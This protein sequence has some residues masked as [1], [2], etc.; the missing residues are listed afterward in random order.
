M[1]CKV[2]TFFSFHQIFSQISSQ[3]AQYQ[4]NKFSSPAN[5]ISRLQT[6]LSEEPHPLPH[7][8]QPVADG[9]ISN[10]PVAPA[11]APDGVISNDPIAQHNLL[12]QLRHRGK[13]STIAFRGLAWKVF[14]SAVQSLRLWKLLADIKM[15][16]DII[17]FIFLRE[18]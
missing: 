14:L 5:P 16:S 7:A 2:T 17:I 9:V 13:L 3:L 4:Q 18:V 6:P 11:P 12:H 10:H 8:A 1:E 15:D